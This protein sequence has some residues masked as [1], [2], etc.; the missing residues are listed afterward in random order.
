MQ[1]P[2][3][4][5]TVYVSPGNSDDKLTQ[6]RWSE[7]ATAVS[8]ACRQAAWEVHGD[9]ASVSTAPWQN[10]CV[11]IEID[12][13]YVPELKRQL[14]DLATVY[15]QDAIA[16]SEARTEFIRPRVLTVH[17]TTAGRTPTGTAA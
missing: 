1:Q 14:A 7:Y 9:W 12:P 15:N 6:A 8:H 3:H 2:D 16:W 13:R 17:R 10:A 4:L 11:C 5:V